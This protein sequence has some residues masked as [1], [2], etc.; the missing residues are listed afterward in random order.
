LSFDFS[1][2]LF[3]INLFYEKW[4]LLIENITINWLENN[5]YEN[6]DYVNFFEVDFTI[7]SVKEKN[8]QFFDR[9]S[10]ISHQ[11]LCSSIFFILLSYYFVS[12]FFSLLLLT[13]TYFYL[14]LITFL[15]FPPLIHFLSR[16]FCTHIFTLQQSLIIPE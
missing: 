14:L 8:L 4:S 7:L 6:F 12:L 13:S 15:L 3:E 11:F 9:Y 16:H 1:N 5:H 10:W 2:K